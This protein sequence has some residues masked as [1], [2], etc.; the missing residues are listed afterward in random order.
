MDKETRAQI[1]AWSIDWEGCI[2]IKRVGSQRIPYVRI[3]NTNVELLLAIQAVA[4]IGSVYPVRGELG[5]SKPMFVWIVSK[6]DDV[7]Q[8]CVDIIP[9]VHAKKRQAEIAIEVLDLNKQTIEERHKRRG[10]W[11]VMLPVGWKEDIAAKV[12]K[13][14]VEMHALNKR[15]IK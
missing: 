5:N 12:D 15:G 8:L 13:L 6:K 7:R 14:V 2:A 11:A 1:L 3:V 9:H 10:G 4:S